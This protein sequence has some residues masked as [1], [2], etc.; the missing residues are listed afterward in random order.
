MS[1]GLQW[2]LELQNGDGG[3]PTYHCEDSTQQFDD[4]GTDLTAE[5][6][7]ALA[8]WQRFWEMS[9]SRQSKTQQTHAVV[10]ANIAPSIERAI[11]FLEARQRDDGSFIPIWFGNEHQLEDEN[12]V[13]GTAQVLMACAELQRLD[14][15]MAMRAAGWLVASQHTAGGW[16]PPRVPVDHSGDQYRGT[17]S[18]R[19]TDALAK[20]CSIEETAA[21]V[22]ALFSLAATNPAYERSVSRG[23]SWLATAVEQ[24]AHRRPAI[25]GFYFSRI[26]YYERLYPLAFAAGALTRAVGVLTPA[27]HETAPT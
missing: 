24:D 20:F 10:F 21:S 19:K 7:R 12:P 25:L 27:T 8:V 15:N 13:M 22:S 4:S 3:W 18:W 16:G 5:A 14:S 1:L 11:R 23:L 6:L 9:P 26:W 17:R 2:L